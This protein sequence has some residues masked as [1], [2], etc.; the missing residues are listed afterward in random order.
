MQAVVAET[1]E[2]LTAK[3]KDSWRLEFERVAQA[4]RE[5]ARA[6]GIE[7]MSME[8]IDAIIA[9]CRLEMKRESQQ[10]KGANEPF[11]GL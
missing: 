11:S 1:Q 2:T 4:M 8:E 5:E 9:E 7:E 10:G 6:A 3:S